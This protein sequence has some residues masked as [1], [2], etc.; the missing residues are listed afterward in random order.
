MLCVIYWYIHKYINIIF[1]NIKQN[2]E[3]IHYLISFQ[4]MIKIHFSIDFQIFAQRNLF[5]LSDYPIL[6]F[7]VINQ[8]LVLKT[9]NCQ[10]VF[11]KGQKVKKISKISKIC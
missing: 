8:V 5:E 11:E 7:S 2:K 10:S 3:F 4:S 1:W 9:L 6:K